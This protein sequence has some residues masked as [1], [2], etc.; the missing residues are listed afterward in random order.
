VDVAVVVRALLDLLELP[1][2]AEVGREEGAQEDAGE[3]APPL[4]AVVMTMSH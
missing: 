2:P 3:G 4:Q 1:T